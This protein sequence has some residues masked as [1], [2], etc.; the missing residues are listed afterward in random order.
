MGPDEINYHVRT[1]PGL[2][3]VDF[4]CA[5]K[6]IMRE[7]RKLGENELH[8]SSR[9][10]F[11]LFSDEANMSLLLDDIQEMEFRSLMKKAEQKTASKRMERDHVI[12]VIEKVAKPS[13]FDDYNNVMHYDFSIC[14]KNV[15]ISVPYRRDGSIVTEDFVHSFIAVAGMLY[16]GEKEYTEICE[17]LKRELI[18]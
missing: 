17:Y 15:T 16:D 2:V 14:G 9:P 4:Y 10:V 8:T 1:T 6:I 12:E 3:R 18:K 11:T 5:D 7:A 13:C